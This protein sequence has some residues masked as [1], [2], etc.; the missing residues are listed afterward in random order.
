MSYRRAQLKWAFKP[1]KAI[2]LFVASLLIAVPF[3]EAHVRKDAQMKARVFRP[4]SYRML[5]YQPVV[6]QTDWYTCGAAALATLFTH[7]YRQPKSEAEMLQ[8]AIRFMEEKDQD[9]T[10][11]LTLL[12]LKQT[13]EFHGVAVAG[14]RVDID[15]LTTYLKKGGGPVIMHIT[16]P[17]S[18]FVVGVGE[19]KGTLVI[20][21]P[22]HGIRGI[23]TESFVRE[24]GFEGNVLV[25]RPSDDAARIAAA[26]QQDVINAFTSDQ[27]R[28]R[29]FAHSLRD[30]SR[31]RGVAR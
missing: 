8:T 20:A 24:T 5:R 19:V 18:H 13:L 9:P 25:P 21:D 30:H 1:A 10:T 31:G 16:R 27:A 7:F 29:R 4:R 23:P 11:G 26:V 28:L 15:A 14:Y 6:G 22:S 12:S 3:A 17:R 2:C